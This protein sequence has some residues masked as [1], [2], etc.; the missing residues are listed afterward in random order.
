VTE[1]A[2]VDQG[3][4]P[5]PWSTLKKTHRNTVQSVK[6][7]LRGD[8]VDLVDRLEED[9]RREADVDTRENRIPVAP[10][11]AEQIRAAEDEARL[12]QVVFR[13]EGLGRGAFA[14]LQAEHPPTDA[15]LET[16]GR[17]LEFNPETFP[18]ALMAATCVA[19]EELRGNVAE[20]TEINDGW[21]LGQTQRIWGACLA[22]NMVVATAPKSEYAS[23]VLRRLGSVTN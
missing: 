3:I 11:I 5:V 18:P 22:A 17:D 4:D 12:S 8:L 1:P 23:E 7:T 13:F 15:Q 19:P 20:W 21:N 14:K 16:V 2:L 6:V 9:M 10:Q